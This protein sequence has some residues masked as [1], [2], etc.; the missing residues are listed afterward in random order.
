MKAAWIG[1]LGAVIG[2]LIGV[3]GAPHYKSWL[4]GPPEGLFLVEL[5][6]IYQFQIPAQLRDQIVKYPCSLKISH[7]DGP[8]V[9]GL[10]VTITSENILSDIT[11]KRNDENIAPKLEADG[12]MLQVE[13]SKLRMNS[14]IDLG[15]FS[16]GSPRL[17]KNV[18]MS[19][20]R[21]IGEAP[22]KSKEQWYTSDYFVLPA[23]IS[24]I[25]IG[26]LLL[27]YLLRRFA[28][29]HLGD[30]KLDK[31]KFYATLAAVI[32]FFPFLRYLSTI[33]IVYALVNVY[34]EIILLRQTIQKDITIKKQ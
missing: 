22:T 28:E 26:C 21:L 34:R 30:M 7:L 14:I 3:F 8:P 20:G 11:V 5:S 13:I 16:D 1:F 29:P 10:S 19:K 9:E 12:K 25:A 18:I 27:F 17:Q 33:F 6:G 31:F 15:F 23:I 24:A 32:A 2:S 4:E